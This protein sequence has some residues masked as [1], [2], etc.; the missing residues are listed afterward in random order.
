MQWLGSLGRSKSDSKRAII[1]FGI[2][3]SNVYIVDE[4]LNLMDTVTLLSNFHRDQNISEDT[5]TSI[6][7]DSDLRIDLINYFKIN[8]DR[9]FAIALLDRFIAIRL[10]PDGEMPFE[11][12]MLASYILGLHGNIEDCL[13][14][15]DAKYA[16]FDTY[17]GFDTGLMLFADSEKTLDFLKNQPDDNSKKAFAYL[18][19]RL[20]GAGANELKGYYLNTALPWYV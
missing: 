17:L 11:D 2:V 19:D 7:T 15:W 6:Q 10:Q 9:Q 14:I 8:K 16:D 1:N 4:H 20:K 12:L 3:E 13:K 5:I 18:S